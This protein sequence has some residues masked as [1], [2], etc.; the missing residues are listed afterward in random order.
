MKF[1]YA[2]IANCLWMCK[3]YCYQPVTH[4]NSAYSSSVVHKNEYQLTTL[5]VTH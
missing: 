5:H 1:L 4:I 2:W 3:S